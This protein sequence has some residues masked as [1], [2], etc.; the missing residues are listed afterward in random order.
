MADLLKLVYWDDPALS[1]VCETVM[2]N[3]FGPKM[4]EFGQQL[5]ATM[6]AAPGVG[7]AAPQVGITKRIFAMRFPDH[8][9]LKPMVIVNPT[10]ELSGSTRYE[11]EGCLSVPG[12]FEQVARAE[13][14]DLRFKTLDNIEA[15]MELT[16]IDAR[17]AQHEF[18][19]LN[20]IM[21]F[22]YLDV[23]PTY[24]RR[25]SKQVSKQV[26]REWEREKAKRGL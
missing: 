6:D 8:E 15:V 19:H 4:E 18:D 9:G 21:F 7:L 22:N 12:V 13:K 17:V 10:L 20:G 24:G 26:L 16:N 2:D 25:M 23:R 14:A 3:E 11:R 5:L 1:T